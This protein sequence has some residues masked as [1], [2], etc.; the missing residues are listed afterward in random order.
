MIY[1][2]SKVTI[3]FKVLANDDNADFG[4]KMIFNLNK[5]LFDLI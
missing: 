1:K 2:I 5:E 4:N 3:D